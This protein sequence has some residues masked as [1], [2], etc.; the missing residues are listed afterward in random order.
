M[1]RERMIAAAA[2]LTLTCAAACRLLQSGP[3]DQEVV[4]AVQ[5]APPAPPTLGPTYLAQIESVQVQ[6][7]GP[8]NDDGKY[9]PVRVRV[10]GG[11]KIRVTNAFQLGLVGEVAKEPPKP[12]DF[13]EGARFTKDDFGKWHVSYNYDAHGPKWRLDDRETS[14]TGR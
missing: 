9:W 13:V 1:V 14:R 2:A 3:S 10:K 7:R 5:K 4:A 8:Y 12:M 11:V 6:E